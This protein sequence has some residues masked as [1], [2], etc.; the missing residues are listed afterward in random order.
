MMSLPRT[1]RSVLTKRGSS[2]TTESSSS[3]CKMKTL[4]I[5][6]CLATSQQ[7]SPKTQKYADTIEVCCQ[8]GF[9]DISRRVHPQ[10]VLTSLQGSVP[11]Q[12]REG[13]PITSGTLPTTQLS[14]AKFQQL[15]RSDDFTK[16]SEEFADNSIEFAN[17]SGGIRPQL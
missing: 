15:T 7:S 3:T 5:L 16:N 10:L 17:N 2:Q 13:S 12:L 6:N 8:P 1:Q 4:R 9:D 14:S 11:Q